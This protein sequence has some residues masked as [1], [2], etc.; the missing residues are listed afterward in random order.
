MASI[1][2]KFRPSTVADLEGTIYFQIIHNR[3]P[4]QLLTEYRVMPCEWD[5]RRS[6][7]LIFPDSKRKA[8]LLSIRERI[9]LDIERLSRI[10]KKYDV[11]ELEYS[12]DDVIREFNR[13]SIEYSLFSF[14]NNI[15]EKL[16]QN[17]KIRT[18][19]TYR[20]TL[21]SFRAFRN[22]KDMLLDCIS[23]EIME[24]YE[25]WLHNRGVA[26]NTISFYNRILRAVYNRAV[27]DE[28]I[29]DRKPFRHVYTG[30]NKTV[31]RALPLIVLKKIKNLDLSLNSGL[32][33]ARDMFIMS[34]Y[35]RGMSFI[36]MA[37]LKK[38]DLKNGYVTYRR[39]KTGQK[40]IIKWTKEMQLLLDKYPENNS[41]YLLPIIR[42]SG[43]NERCVYRNAAYRINYRLKI[44]A[45]MV[46]VTIPL[47][48]YVARHSWA[49]AAKA[50]GIPVSVI[51]E[52]MGH[53]SETTT[54]IYLASLDTS[55]VD[56]A[57]SL[58]IKAL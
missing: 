6:T 34:F 14:F 58:I 29:V 51:S 12:A 24:A 38:S 1:K 33:F 50:K 20:S 57:N 17:G 26:P 49:S 44:I 42:N 25:A 4:R 35:L 15:I 41:N 46:G 13:H 55:I 36:D 31:K 45:A 37:Y 8:L 2:L 32:C 43:T 30:I 10:I 7:I 18:S 48:L 27:E 16:K 9:Q 56:K 3:K 54:Q 39:H 11:A 28:I 5:E 53:D 52:G 40:L 21:N 19:E 47:T 23:S 22:D